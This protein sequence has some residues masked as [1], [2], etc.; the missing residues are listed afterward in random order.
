M[1]SDGSAQIFNTLLILVLGLIIGALAWDK[2]NRPTT[3]AQAPVNHEYEYN[4]PREEPALYRNSY[5][6]QNPQ[7]NGR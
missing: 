1:R 7:Y 3:P 2:F 4:R 5:A 6:P